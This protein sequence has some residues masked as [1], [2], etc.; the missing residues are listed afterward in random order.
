MELKVLDIISGEMSAVF[1]KN[2][3]TG[4]NGVYTKDGK[5]VKISYD[6]IKKLCSLDCKGDGDFAAIATWL[7][8]EST[9]ENDAKSVVLDFTES[10]EKLIGIKKQVGKENIKLPTK[11]DIGETP[12]VT[13]LCQKFLAI[14]PQYKDTYR[15]HMAEYGAF[16]PIIF[17]KATAMAELK[18]QLETN[19]K[20]LT[21]YV[22]MLSSLYAEGD[23]E[24]GN[25]VAGVIISGAVK[26]DAALYEKLMG[27][28]DSP[29]L[30][31]AL[32]SIVPMAS[33][34]AK[35]KKVLE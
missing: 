12:N 6:E 34:N 14:F 5:S 29:Y 23:R 33:K 30:K 2:G 32:Q 21:K 26:D 20:Q 4:E 22:S 8:D 31:P 15:E 17:F 9:S 35:L 13:A 7:V 10:F 11:A 28:I 1:E 3:F 25:I 27:L 18:K 16:L 24:V 19:G